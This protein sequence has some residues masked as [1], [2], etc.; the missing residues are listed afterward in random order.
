MIICSNKPEILFWDMETHKFHLFI[1]LSFLRNFLLVGA[2]INSLCIDYHDFTTNY[3]WLI[4]NKASPALSP[5]LSC[6]CRRRVRVCMPFG[7]GII[8]ELILGSGTRP[9]WMARLRF[10]FYDWNRNWNWNF[11]MYNPHHLLLLFLILHSSCRA[12]NKSQILMNQKETE[13]N[14]YRIVSID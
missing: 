7:C 4:Q 2:L 8:L 5:H 11:I 12:Q 3:S 13:N 10:E 1:P 14:Q 9:L 6:W